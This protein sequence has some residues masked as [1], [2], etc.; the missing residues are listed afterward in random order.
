MQT[1]DDAQPSPYAGLARKIRG[2][3][4]P[5]AVEYESR[6]PSLSVTRCDFESGAWHRWR[7]FRRL[8]LFVMFGMFGWIVSL[9]PF[10]VELDGQIVGQLSRGER[11]TFDVTPGEHT[12][13]VTT[14]ITSSR[15]IRID[16]KNGQRFRFSCQT[17]FT[18]II[19][20]QND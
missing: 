16:I 10:R 5:S 6:L 7:R 13:R 17:K 20:Q 14:P 18:G 19:F 12:I 8:K 3:K 1:P 9:Q 15:T 11:L 2:G 4:S